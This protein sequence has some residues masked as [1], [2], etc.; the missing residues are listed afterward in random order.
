MHVEEAG[1]KTG[2]LER[3]GKKKKDIPKDV[4][5]AEVEEKK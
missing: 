5:E 3:A 2:D 1:K 4:A